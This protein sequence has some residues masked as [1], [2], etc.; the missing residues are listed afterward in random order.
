MTNVQ[1]WQII[2]AVIA[3]VTG[4]LGGAIFKAIWDARSNRIQPIGRKIEILP[5]LKPPTTDTGL[6]TRIVVTRGT[7]H[8]QFRN[9]FLFDIEVLNKG[10]QDNKEFVFGATLQ[11]SNQAIYV[12]YET[13]DRHH[14]VTHTPVAPDD[15]KTEIDFTLKPFN[16]KDPYRLKVYVVIPEG[17]TE[18]SELKLSSPHPVKF[19][20]ILSLAEIVAA[21]ATQIA[22]VRVGPFGV[23]ISSK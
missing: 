15:P 1:K 23:T 16:R 5:I 11:D 21:S 6:D 18:P 14:T 19:T 17:K 12:E 20:D 3:L 2:I 9:L 4:G 13:P 10:G 8:H 22:T 7:S